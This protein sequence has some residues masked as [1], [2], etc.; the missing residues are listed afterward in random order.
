MAKSASTVAVESLRDGSSINESAQNVLVVLTDTHVDQRLIH[1]AG[2]YAR[3]IGSRLVLL[4]VMPS[5]EFAERQQAYAQIRDFPTY[6]LSQA[7]EKHRQ[8]AVQSGLE[9]LDSLDIEYTAVGAV[10]READQVLATAREHD[11]GHVFLVD[12]PRSLL[13]RFLGNDSIQAITRGFDGSVTTLQ[14]TPSL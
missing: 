5:R 1:E 8:K 10:G 11:C 14:D 4:S 12:R 6:A 13:R 9:T 3:G 2:A 7:E